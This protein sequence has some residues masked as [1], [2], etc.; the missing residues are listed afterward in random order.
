MSGPLETL[1]FSLAFRSLQRPFL[2]DSCRS[3]QHISQFVT[4]VYELISI[5]C[6]FHPG[7]SLFGKFSF[8]L[9]FFHLSFRYRFAFPRVYNYFIVVRDNRSD[10]WNEWDTVNL[11]LMNQ[12]GTPSLLAQRRVKKPAPTI[13]ITIIIILSLYYHFFCIWY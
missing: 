3:L 12:C 10:V 6:F 5:V 11:W 2:S 13:I 9:R 4:S 8:S 7:P 1:K